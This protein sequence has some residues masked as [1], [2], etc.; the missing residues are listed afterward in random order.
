MGPYFQE[1]SDADPH[2][3]RINSCSWHRRLTRTP[4]LICHG[5]YFPALHRQRYCDT[6]DGWFHVQCLGEK[7]RVDFDPPAV[8]AKIDVDEVDENG[9]PLIWERVLACPTLRGHPG[10][11]YDFDNS[12]LITGNGTQKKWI[13]EWMES[14]AYPENWQALFGEDFLKDVLSHD[15]RQYDCLTCGNRV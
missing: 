6:C 5:E 12:W 2:P 4:C 1:W 9:F 15:F 8:V 11:P 14:T 7:S 13:K 3:Q 10:P